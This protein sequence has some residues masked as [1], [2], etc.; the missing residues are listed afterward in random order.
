MN[1]AVS[2]S[3]H[4]EERGG[5][6]DKQAQGDPGMRK[7]ADLIDA[8]KIAMLTTE[9]A[10]GSLRSRP[11]ATLQLDS[12]GHLWFFTAMSSGKVE[13]I[14]QHR[15]VNLSYANVDKQ[16]YVSVSGH[17]RLLRD[18]EKMKQLWTRWV[19]PWF[20]NG[21][22][23]PDLALLEVTIDEAE[24]WDA[25]ASR[26]QRFFGLTRALSS[27]DTSGMGEHGKVRPR[28]NT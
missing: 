23:D 13:E 27:G 19:E 22:D 3:G 1:S 8:A 18:R 7:L 24:Y 9:E 16:D 15:K 21:V 6:V 26:M 17:A 28:T 11:L 5:A 20:P 12:E 10:D 14:D 4:T 2:V 25:P